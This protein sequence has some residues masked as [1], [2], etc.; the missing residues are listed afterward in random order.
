MIDHFLELFVSEATTRLKELNGA[1][2]DSDM[3]SLSRLSHSIANVT[4]TLRGQEALTVARRI[5][6]CLR[7][8]GCDGL[9][10]DMAILNVAVQ[11]MI[12]VARAYLDDH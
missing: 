11:Q 12:D 3:T 4:G 10:E 8:G 5:E 6:S 9:G 7:A 2:R 1:Y